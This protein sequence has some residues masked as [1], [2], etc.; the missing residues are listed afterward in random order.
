VGRTRLTVHLGPG[1]SGDLWAW[2]VSLAEAASGRVEV[3][4][5]TSTFEP[6]AKREH[7]CRAR[8]MPDWWHELSGA[9]A[10]VQFGVLPPSKNWTITVDDAPTL[11]VELQQD[12]L[13]SGFSISYAPELWPALPEQTRD[14]LQ[15]VV[16]I[17]DPIA[18][19]LHRS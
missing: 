5:E 11:T 13:V 4:W 2:K 10:H 18:R 8:T 16:A 1:F 9:L 6:S 7:R 12:D 15:Q 14:A 17:L 3:V 19:D